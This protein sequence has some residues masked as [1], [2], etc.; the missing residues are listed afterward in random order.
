LK[1]WR[2]TVRQ[3]LYRYITK[4]GDY[5]NLSVL[6]KFE[7]KETLSLLELAVWKAQSVDGWIFETQKK[8]ENNRHWM[9]NL[10]HPRI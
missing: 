1:R 9:K 10:T 6:E 4:G 3:S 5:D 8:F 2:D 7:R